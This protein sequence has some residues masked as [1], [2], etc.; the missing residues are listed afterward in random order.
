MALINKLEA[1]GDAIREKTGGTEELTL[2]QMATAINGLSIGGGTLQTAVITRAFSTTIYLDNYV[3]VAAG[4]NFILFYTYRA[5]SSASFMKAIHMPAFG[6]YIYSLTANTVNSDTNG[7]TN[8]GIESIG[9]TNVAE[10]NRAMA[11]QTNSTIDEDRLNRGHIFFSSA[12]GCELGDT[13]I[14]VYVG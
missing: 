12:S 1:I 2:E 11:Y 8:D 7:E 3:D 4:D 6:K 10:V 14:L 5:Y 9:T 13:A